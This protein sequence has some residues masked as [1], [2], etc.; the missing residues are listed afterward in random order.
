M[1][2]GGSNP[3][4]EPG[5]SPAGPP[6]RYVVPRRTGYGETSLVAPNASEPGSQRP[7][8][9]MSASRSKIT[10]GEP[11][12]RAVKRECEVLIV[13]D[14]IWCHRIRFSSAAYLAFDER[15]WRDVQ[16]HAV[17]LPGGALSGSFR[18]SR[19]G[20]HARRAGTCQ[21]GHPHTQKVARHGWAE[22][23]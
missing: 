19:A 20:D 9:G 10:S 11:S 13:C 15:P 5:R 14:S 8:F 12:I 6:S 3:V 2:F 7:Y 22:D 21:G 18:R 1:D 4:T 16:A 23:E 17:P